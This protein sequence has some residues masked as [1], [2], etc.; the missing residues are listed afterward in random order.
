MLCTLCQSSNQ[1]EFPV[2]MMIH[3]SGIRQIDTP[4][5]L[6]FPKVS[7]SL[8]CG[9]SGFNTPE[10]QLRVLGKAIAGPVAA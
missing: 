9:F 6:A 5:V 8:D 4:S 3:F 10:T 2:E 1:A 7:V